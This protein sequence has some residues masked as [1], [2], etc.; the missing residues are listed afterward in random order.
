MPAIPPASGTEQAITESIHPTDKQVHRIAAHES[1]RNSAN[2]C[3]F[4]LELV[5]PLAGEN[6]PMFSNKDVAKLK[7]KYADDNNS[8]FVERVICLWRDNQDGTIETLMECLELHG[9]ALVK[10]AKSVFGLK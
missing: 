4:V 10:H 3:E 6:K 1:I 7:E 5:L 2:I 8:Q 9:H